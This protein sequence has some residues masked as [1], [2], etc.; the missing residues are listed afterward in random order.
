MNSIEKENHFED[1]RRAARARSAITAENIE[2]VHQLI[3]IYDITTD[4][5][6]F[7]DWIGSN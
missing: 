5:R 4:K 1:E 2:A 6:H 3:H 7:T